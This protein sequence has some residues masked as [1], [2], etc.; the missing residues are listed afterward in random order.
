[1][2]TYA[3]CWPQKNKF[4]ER[5]VSARLQVGQKSG[6]GQNVTRTKQPQKGLMSK[7]SNTCMQG[8]TSL[9]AHSLGISSV[10]DWLSIVL[11]L[12]SPEKAVV[13]LHV[14]SY[15][16]FGSLLIIL[17][18]KTPNDISSWLYSDWVRLPLPDDKARPG[19]VAARLDWLCFYILWGH[20]TSFSEWKTLVWFFFFSHYPS[21]TPDV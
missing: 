9:L 16:H 7:V 5:H 11:R 8:F 17:Y 20:V 14:G 15:G 10:V 21:L 6:T 13:P 4:M 3:L 19:C 2:Q 1:M 12:P 18:H